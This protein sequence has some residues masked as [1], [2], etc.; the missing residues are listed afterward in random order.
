VNDVT[1][2]QKYVL[3]LCLIILTFIANMFGAK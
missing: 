3:T 2:I 1:F